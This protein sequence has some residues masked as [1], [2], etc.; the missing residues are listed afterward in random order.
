MIRFLRQ[1]RLPV[2]DNKVCNMKNE[3]G[4]E[5]QV[6]NMSHDLLMRY[7]YWFLSN[8]STNKK[9]HVLNGSIVIESMLQI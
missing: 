7:E 9:S 4:T 3:R 5:V 8:V 6:S 2:V 1:V